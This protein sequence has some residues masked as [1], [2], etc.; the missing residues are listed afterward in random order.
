MDY[1]QPT[2]GNVSEVR[3]AKEQLKIRKKAEEIRKRNLAAE[4]RRKA[5]ETKQKK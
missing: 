5:Q 4:L 2:A 1:Q 3:Y